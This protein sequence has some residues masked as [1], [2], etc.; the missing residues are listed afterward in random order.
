[1]TADLARAHA[2]AEQ[3]AT[4]SRGLVLTIAFGA[5]LQALNASTMAVAMVDIREHFHAGSDASWLISGLYLATAVGSPTAGRLADLFGPR[6]VFLTSLGLTVVASVAAPL[7][8]T[9]GWLIAFRVLLG[10][11][12]CAAFPAGISLL[13][14]EAD[15]LGM[16]LPAGALSVMAIGGQVMIAGGPVI[17]G[18]LV[19]YWG[20]PAIFLVNL[21]LGV[22]GLVL[23]L[24]WLPRGGVRVPGGRSALGRLDLAGAGLFAAVI[25]TLM[26]FLLSLS[27][28]PWWW[29]LPVL[30]VLG[31]VFVVFELRAAE[32]FVDVRMLGRNRA[33]TGTYLRTALTYVAF[34]VMFFGFPMWLESG[35]GLA[36]GHVGFVVLPIALTA[37]VAVAGAGRLL[38]RT[39]H[40]PVLLAGSVL[41]GLGGVLLT[42]VNSA[43]AVV[44][45]VAVAAVLGLPNGLN[46]IGNQTA[47]YRQADAADAGI[48]SGLYRTSQYVGANIAAAVIELCFAGAVGDP[49]MHRLG[50]VVAVIS[51]VLVVGA[52]AGLV[53]GR[54]RR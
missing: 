6:R 45:L 3:S 23:A 48:A 9:L 1:M 49:G 54:L 43:S 26:L 18:V 35:R 19:Q 25:A 22:V 7:S 20:W 50:A 47:L 14:Q 2:P 15:R 46:N 38:R 32:P 39:G 30:A 12:T 41:L 33:L 27:G 8:P 17:G 34:Y 36:P 28:R 5:V 29:L 11:G 51:A 40:W 53:G 21:P 44:V 16:P 13:R 42:Q 37:M 4:L 31:A 52:V 10:I 24:V